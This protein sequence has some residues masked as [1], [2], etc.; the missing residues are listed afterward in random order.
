MWRDMSSHVPKAV[1]LLSGG[2]DSSTTLAIVRHEGF[3]C[4]ALSFDYG[5]RHRCELEA[6]CGIAKSMNVADHRIVKIDLG[7][8]TVLPLRS[9]R[10]RRR[11]L[12]GPGSRPGVTPP[13]PRSMRWN[14][15]ISATRLR[16]L[17]ATGGPAVSSVPMARRYHAAPAEPSPD[18]VKRRR[19]RPAAVGITL[20][21]VVSPGARCGRPQLP[22][23]TTT[24]RSPTRPPAVPRA[25]PGDA[26]RATRTAAARAP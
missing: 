15:A 22:W 23:L 4:H 17:A 26:A 21:S 12:A 18:S 9:G 14:H 16:R 19:R 25:V 10:A 24:R 7:A 3:Q 8:R 1:V 2:V 6:A 13:P 5:Q 20:A 11:S